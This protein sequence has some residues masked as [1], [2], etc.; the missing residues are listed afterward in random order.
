MA[1]AAP[2][3]AGSDAGVADLSDARSTDSDMSAT[4]SVSRASATSGASKASATSAASKELSGKKKKKQERFQKPDPDMWN[5]MA[6]VDWDDCESEATECSSEYLETDVGDSLIRAAQVGDLQV[7]D[8][9]LRSIDSEILNFKDQDGYTPLH[10]ATYNG[11]IEVMK[12]LMSAGADVISETN[13]GWHPL[14]CACR[15]NQTEAASLLL[16][17]GG[18]INAQTKGG[19]TPLHL[20]ASMRDGGPTLV[21][22]L[23]HRDIKPHMINGAGETPLDLAKRNGTHASLFEMVEDSV[24]VH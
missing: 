14:H 7:V 22:L 9:I 10:R 1:A 11:H 17:N 3:E 20:A 5:S 13:D 21:L 19:Q 2:S 24:W 6:V 15:W 16:Q 8:T 12:R 23:M 18:D 4:S